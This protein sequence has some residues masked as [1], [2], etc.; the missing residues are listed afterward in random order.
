MRQNKGEGRTSLLAFPGSGSYVS[1]RVK[2][3]TIHLQSRFF[4]DDV[5]RVKVKIV[6]LWRGNEAFTT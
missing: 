2:I 4:D 1:Q 5:E 6:V 3:L